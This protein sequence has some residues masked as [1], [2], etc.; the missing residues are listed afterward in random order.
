MIMDWLILLLL[1]PAIIV[2]IVLLC[3]FAGCAPLAQACE[4]DGDCPAGTRCVDGACVEGVLAG[5]RPSAPVDL[6]ANAVSDSEI[7]LSWTNNELA[8]INFQVQRAEEDEDFAPISE[9]TGQTFQDTGLEEG[10]TYLYQ[11]RAF[12]GEEFSEPSNQTTATTFPKAPSNLIATPVEVDR[13]D[14]SWTNDSAR[15]TLFSLEHRLITSPPTSFAEIVPGPGTGTSFP[16]T[17]LAE[18]SDHEY[19]VIAIIPIG[20][21]NGVQ[22]P[23]RSAPSATVS[24]RTWARAF[25]AVLTTDQAGLEGFCLIQRIS[26]AQLG[27]FPTLLNNIGTTVRIT[28]RG[29]TTGNLTINRIYIS[30]VAASGDPWDSAAD[31]TKVVD[32]DQGDP[33]VVLPANTPQVLGPINYALDRTQ[34]LLIAFDISATAAQGNVISVQPGAEHYFKLGTQESSVPDRASDFSTGLNRHYLVQKIEVL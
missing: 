33:A 16:H 12:D 10:T 24:A 28:L 26:I 1:V 20:F 17:G 29:S 22:Q 13:I 18:G 27:I 30:Q 6:G 8:V 9:P 5:R 2:P 11:V 15:A 19:R 32:I 23:V 4:G 7:D 25:E 34:D 14:L 3:G 21:Q 31:I